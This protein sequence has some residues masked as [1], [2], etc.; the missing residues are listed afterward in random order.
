M[1]NCIDIHRARTTSAV[2]VGRPA[3]TCVG[4]HSPPYGFQRCSRLAMASVL[5]LVLGACAAPGPSKQSPRTQVK[6][7]A[8]APKPE[9]GARKEIAAEASKGDP[10]SRFQE[11]LRLM[12]ARQFPQAQA[13][14]LALSRDYPNFSGPLTDLGILYAQTHQRELAVASLT[15]AV[16]ANPGNAVALNWLGTLH[17]ENQDFVRAEQ[18]YRK[19]IT[20]RPAYAQA[21]LNL[22]ILYDVALHRPQ[23][24]LA[25]YREY[26]RLAGTD[27]LVVAAWIREIE[28][29]LQ[30][31]PAATTTVAGATP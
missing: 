13:A 12:K 14:F 8:S 4:G 1:T 6:T 18:S 30:P 10:D 19:A 24:A 3:A 11:A 16:Q 21:H 28:A 25:S 20:A 26:Q 31:A 5:A 15:R 7:P 27:D 22:A 9:P 17:R 23:E 2:G 29:R